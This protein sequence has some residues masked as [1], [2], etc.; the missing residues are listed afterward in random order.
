M[1]VVTALARRRRSEDGAQAY[2]RTLRQVSCQLEPQIVAERGLPTTLAL[3]PC[4]GFAEQSSR[5]LERTLDVLSEQRTVSPLQVVVLINRPPDRVPD[6]SEAIARRA[7]ERLDL[8]IAVASVEL[9]RRPRLGE[10]RQLL[11]DA[12]ASIL[13]LR[14]GRAGTIVVLDDDIVDAPTT[15][16]QELCTAL[17][18]GH[19]ADLAVGPVLFDDPDFPSAM[20]PD[21]L[22]GDLFRALL[23]AAWLDRV[24]GTDL[25]VARECEWLAQVARD[26]F[27][28]I[29]LSCN[30]GVRPDALNRVGGFRDLNEITALARDIQE[31]ALRDR[32][33]NH[34]NENP[35]STT[36]RADGDA[37]GALLDQAVR[38]SSRRALAAYARGHHPSV[39]QWQACRFRSSQVDPVR[40]ADAPTYRVTP[41]RRLGRSERAALVARIERVLTETLHYFP[42]EPGVASECLAQLGLGSGASRLAL[43]GGSTPHWHVSILH[44]DALLGRLVDRQDEPALAE[45]EPE[46]QGA[47]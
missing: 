45:R 13:D 22:A 6:S 25:S 44:P 11:A 23:S 38:I 31:Q 32:A 17:S 33:S 24:A 1:S 37:V 15:F 27:E 29:V 12:T 19:P 21:F 46:S 5:V 8:R 20:L 16:V 26:N 7:A 34:G 42:T 35:I 10:L 14:G 9:P 47:I 2:E 40:V 30:L 28:S 36:F 43:V 4:V 18:G 39:A 3:L 41:I